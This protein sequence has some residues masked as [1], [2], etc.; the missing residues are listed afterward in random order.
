[1]GTRGSRVAAAFALLMLAS[2]L[3]RTPAPVFYT[4][5]AVVP[6]VAAAAEDGPI[7]LAADLGEVPGACVIAGA[8]TVARTPSGSAHEILITASV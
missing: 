2:C 4:L 6:P 5:S 3:G 1:M 8:W 7:G